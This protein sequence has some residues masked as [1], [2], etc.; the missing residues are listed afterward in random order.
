MKEELKNNEIEIREL[1]R[2]WYDGTTS[3]EEERRLK[4][5][6]LRSSQLPPD[7]EADKKL[8]EGLSAMGEES[9]PIPDHLQSR[10]SDAIEKEIKTSKPLANKTHTELASLFRARKLRMAIGGVAVCLAGIFFTNRMM[11]IPEMKIEPGDKLA[12]NAPGKTFQTDDSLYTHHLTLAAT[13]SEVKE[14]KKKKIQ[15]LT[16]GKGVKAT[17]R[18]RKNHNSAM[19]F[20]STTGNEEDYTEYL[21]AE[22]E[23]RLERRNYRVVRDE[24]EA[25]AI[26]NSFFSQLESNVAMETSRLSRV[27]LEYEAEMMKISEL[28]NYNE[29]KPTDY[30][31]S[32]L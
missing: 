7:L 9:V 21:S 31:Y 28:D 1:L 12:L 19:V 22:E 32:P 5:L 23:E 24:A 6:L 29:I 3:K 8:F 11:N 30:E 4:C 27:G 16:P 17:A 25:D 14:E 10:I 18:A 20:N 2:R 15:S 13:E 26:L